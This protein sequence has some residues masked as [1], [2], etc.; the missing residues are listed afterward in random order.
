MPPDLS[1]F[2]LC[3]LNY[4]C[5]K[6]IFVVPKVFQ[7]SN[8]AVYDNWMSWAQV[9]NH[10]LNLRNS[11]NLRSEI[12]GVNK[13]LQNQNLCHIFLLLKPHEHSQQDYAKP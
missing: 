2:T 12:S 6:H 8:K 3:S 13:S 4:P 1:L 10:S 11:L 9:H 7:P 5:L